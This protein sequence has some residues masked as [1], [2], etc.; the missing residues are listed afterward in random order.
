MP[1]IWN[2]P[3]TTNAERKQLL[4]LAVESVQVD[5][6][7]QAGLVE[8]QIHWR[9]GIITSMNAKRPAPGEGSLKTSPEAVARIHALA[10]QLSYA[11]IAE[12]LNREGLCSAFH[13]PFSAYQVGYICR[14]DGIAR[15]SKQHT[16]SAESGTRGAL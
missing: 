1:A 6:V 15:F 4:R 16:R 14:R 13:L 2:A 9:T 3:T 11:G 12:Q 7:Q 8:V 10:G 5:G